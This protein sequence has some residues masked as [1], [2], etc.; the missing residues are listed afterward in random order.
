MWQLLS[1]AVLFLVLF[2]L[3][4]WC[5]VDPLLAPLSNGETCAGVSQSMIFCFNILSIIL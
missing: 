1:P 2:D 4:R 3:W 5:N